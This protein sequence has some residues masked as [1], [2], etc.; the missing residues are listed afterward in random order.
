MKTVFKKVMLLVIFTAAITVLTACGS[1]S[2]KGDLTE[3]S[4]PGSSFTISL[5]AEDTDSWAVEDTDS[6]AVK[7]DT[8]DDT[9]DM[10]DRT[11]VINIQVQSMSKSKAANIASDLTQRRSCVHGK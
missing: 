10:T 2:L 3:Y 1:T 7:D 4:D 8:Q 6:W 5:P 9:L 11:G